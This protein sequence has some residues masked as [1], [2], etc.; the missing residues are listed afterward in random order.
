MQNI[1]THSY[2]YT[3]KYAI[4]KKFYILSHSSEECLWE[5][6]YPNKK[7]IPAVHKNSS[8]SISSSI[9]VIFI[10]FKLIAILGLPRWLSNKESTC[11]S[12]ATGDVGL[13][14]GSGRSP[15]GGHDNPLQS[16]CLENPMDRGTGQAAV[17]G[18]TKSWTWLK[19]LHTHNGHSNEYKVLNKVLAH[20]LCLWACFCFEI[21][22]FVSFLY[23]S[24]ISN[25]TWYL[26]FSVWLTLLSMI[27]P[28]I[29]VWIYGY[30]EGRVWRRDTLG[31][32]YWHIHTAIFKRNNWHGSILN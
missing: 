16:S 6:I 2:I 26:S 29:L 12:G 15:G 31:V 14:P 21:S 17:H 22:S 9:F 7:A 18:V 28:S 13:I 3:Y 27:I 20:S 23:I 5:Y 11:T 8:F 25:I 10:I 19:W 1:Y 4:Y 30:Q 24:H 32:W